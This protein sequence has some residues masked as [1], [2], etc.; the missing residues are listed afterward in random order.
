MLDGLSYDYVDG[1]SR[2]TLI[3]NLER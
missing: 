3:K 2:I 1:T